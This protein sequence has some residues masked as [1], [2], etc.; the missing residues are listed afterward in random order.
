MSETVAYA[1]VPGATK[2]DLVVLALAHPL[3][4]KD[5][6]TLGLSADASTEVGDKIGVRKDHAKALIGG[7]YAQVDPEDKAAVKAILAGGA[8]STA[9][10]DNPP[11]DNPV[12]V[13][14][15]SGETAVATDTADEKSGTR[16][17]T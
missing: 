6:E 2:D 16:K 13:A 8:G 3:N 1:E 12:N 15:A 4:A 9:P 5:R 10:T 11:A 14:P 17:R 7:G